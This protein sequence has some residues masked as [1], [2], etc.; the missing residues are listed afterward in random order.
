M[1]L[2][3][4]SNGICTILA[5]RLSETES[6]QLVCMFTTRGH[7]AVYFARI[8]LNRNQRDQILETHHVQV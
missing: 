8:W 7:K 6:Q 5:D 1:V 2:R 4:D 3:E